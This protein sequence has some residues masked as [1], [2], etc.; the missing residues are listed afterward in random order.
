MPHDLAGGRFD[1]GDAGLRSA[2]RATSPVSARV[3]AAE[4]KP[5]QSGAV[6]LPWRLGRRRAWDWSRARI[7]LAWPAV[8]SRLDCPGTSSDRSRCSRWT[9]WIRARLSFG[10]A[11][12]QQPQ[13][14]E[15]RVVGQHPQGRGADRDHGDG[16]RVVRVGLAVVTGVQRPGPGA[17]LCGDVHD[18][19]AVGQQAFALPMFSDT[20]RCSDGEQQWDDAPDDVSGEDVDQRGCHDACGTQDERPDRRHPQCWRAMGCSPLAGIRVVPGVADP[21]DGTG[22]QDGV[23]VHP[24]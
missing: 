8:M 7:F 1:G 22:A 24:A 5:G 20:A 19:L 6:N 2:N 13:R 11:V 14:L 10:A 3:R 12:D 15:L 23:G 16:V 21:E 17:D 9:H 18:V 4:T